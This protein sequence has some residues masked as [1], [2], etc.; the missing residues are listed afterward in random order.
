[1]PL[2]NFLIIG[3]AKSGTTA[4]FKY[5]EQHPEVFISEPK[6]PHF[7]ALEG[8]PLSFMGPGD[9]QMMNT[10]AITE[11]SKYKS[12]FDRAGT[13]KAIG[14]GS[15]STLYYPDSISRIKKYVPDAK[16]IALL[17]HPADRAWSAF[18]FMHSR[19]FEPLQD[20]EA[21]LDAEQK[22]IAD[23]WHH[24]WHYKRQGLY[25]EQLKPYFE[26]FDRSQIKIYLFDDF[27]KSPSQ[28][29]QDCFRFIGVN[30]NFVPSETPSPHASGMPKSKLLQVLV[31]RTK[32]VRKA[33]KLFVPEKFR[34]KLNRKFEELNLQ[35]EKLE[36]RIRSELTEYFRPDILKLQGLI[37]RDLSGWLN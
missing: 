15:V 35:K 19:V 7:L 13:A 22:R 33:L 26:S 20:F 34:K 9:D 28:V 29:L 32:S 16:L 31:T 37:G 5:L 4:L 30:D 8:K 24:I 17:R 14:E 25:F 1:M 6:E 36:P 27:R 3:A 21:A 18:S 11:F 2:P 10:K 23:G 12:L